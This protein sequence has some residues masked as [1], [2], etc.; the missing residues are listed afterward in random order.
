MKRIVIAVPI[1]LAFIISSSLACLFFLRGTE[2]DADVFIEKVDKAAMSEDYAACLQTLDEFGDFW[3]D[4]EPYY[5]LFVRHEEMHD[6]KIGIEQMKGFAQCRDKSGIIGE[7]RM[8]KAMLAHIT[9]SETPLL[10]NIL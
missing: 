10:R 6:I 5:L 4:R 3:D 2:A 1:L 8:L 7:L 9:E